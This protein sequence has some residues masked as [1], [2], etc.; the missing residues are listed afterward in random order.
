MSFSN[1]AL[2]SP[3]LECLA[4]LGFNQP[5]PIQSEVIPLILEKKRSLS[6][7]TNR[8]WKNSCVCIAHFK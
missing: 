3:L 8:K 2:S 7:S 5:T 6:P 4:T 1:F